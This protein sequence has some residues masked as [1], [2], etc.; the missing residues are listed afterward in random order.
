MSFKKVQ[1]FYYCSLPRK[2]LECNENNSMPHFFNSLFLLKGIQ[3]SKFPIILL[4]L[5]FN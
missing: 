3:S 1:T 2:K 5:R 4:Y